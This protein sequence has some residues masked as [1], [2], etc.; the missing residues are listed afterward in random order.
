MGVTLND[1]QSLGQCFNSY[2]FCF[3]VS[4]KKRVRA[5]CKVKKFYNLKGKGN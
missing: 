1:T 3:K 5:A 4:L 2:N